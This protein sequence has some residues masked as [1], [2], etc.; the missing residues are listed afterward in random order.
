MQIPT[1]AERARIKAWLVLRRN[2]TRDD[3]DL[4]ALSVRLGDRAAAVLVE[5]DPWY[6]DQIGP[7]GERVAT[8]LSRQLAEPPSSDQS[9][10]DLQRYRSLNPRWQDWEAVRGACRAL[11]IAMGERVSLG[12]TP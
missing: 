5:I 4:V 8:Q 3:L 9:D 6:A 11:S 12:G 7:G 1:L 10:V 2:A